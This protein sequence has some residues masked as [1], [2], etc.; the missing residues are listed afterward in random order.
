MV[1]FFPQYVDVE[2]AAGSTTVETR[3]A[4]VRDPEAGNGEG[5]DQ[6]IADDPEAE[7][8]GQGGQGLVVIETV[9]ISPKRDEKRKRGRR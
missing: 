2:V 5:P 1:F 3:I 8:R 4:R 9:V 6:G 7:D